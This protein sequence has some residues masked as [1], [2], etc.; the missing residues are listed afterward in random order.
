MHARASIGINLIGH[1]TLV[2]GLGNTARAF[3]RAMV[4]AGH[5]VAGFDVSIGYSRVASTPP[6]EIEMVSNLQDLPHDIT[7]VCL[8]IHMLPGFILR[9]WSRLNRPGRANFALIYWE[10]PVLP[11]VW[12]KALRLFDGLVAGS[13][14]VRETLERAIPELPCLIAEHP[15]YLPEIQVM[16]RSELGIPSDAVIFAS[17]FD[18]GSDVSRK[19][20]L[21]TLRAF[22]IAFEQSGNVGLV[23]KGSGNLVDIKKHPAGKEILEA[24]R[25]DPRIKLLCETMSYERVLGLYAASD[26][27]VSLHRS[28]GLG[29]GPL[30]AMTLGKPVV[31]TGYSGNLSYMT[32]GNSM[33][34]RYRLIK[35]QNCGW[36][37]RPSY[38]GKGAFWAEVE[39][40]H[41]A[42]LM[43]RLAA[44]PELRASL[45]AIAADTMRQRNEVSKEVS[46]VQ[47]M[48]A[49]AGAMPRK[50]GSANGRIAALLIAELTNATHLRLRLKALV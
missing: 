18:L 27:F 37:Y 11:P 30:E 32:I 19:N 6:S 46:F 17:S 5:R 2:A 43:Q 8:S 38:A 23:L 35:P 42:E 45:G 4:E 1:L 34:A 50:V 3:A 41:A 26:V 14:Y 13:Q 24:T 49:I 40:E 22:Q 9:N 33:A 15:L 48:R 29:L 12:R 36:Q 44:S 25:L 47:D 28:E 39:I 20:P 21:A 31:A 16:R 10:L 7:L